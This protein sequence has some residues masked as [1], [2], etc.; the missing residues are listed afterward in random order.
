MNRKTLQKLID[1]VE[2]GDKAYAMGILDI[3][4]DNLPEENVVLAPGIVMHCENQ[5]AIQDASSDEAKALEYMAKAKLES[6]KM[7]AAE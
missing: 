3:L 5:K 7:M 4:M 2:R 1:A 6:V